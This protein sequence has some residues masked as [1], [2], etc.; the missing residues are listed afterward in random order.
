MVVKNSQI[1]IPVKLT[2]PLN[3]YNKVDVY[4][5]VSGLVIN[6]E[7]RLKP[8]NYYKKGEIILKIDDRIY[9]NNVLSQKSSL[10]NQMTKL[11]PDLSIDYPKS[12]EE[13]KNYLNKF[14]LDLPLQPLPEPSDNTEK[15]YIASRNLY[16]MYYSVRSME[17][18]LAKYTITAPF[19]GVISDGDINPGTLIRTGQKIAT[20]TSSDRFEMKAFASIKQVSRIKPGQKAVLYSEDIPGNFNAFVSRVNT[21]IDPSQTVRVYLESTDS[22]LKDGL[23]MTAVISTDPIENAAKISKALLNE[24]DSVFIIKNNILEARK[25]KVIAQVGDFVI[26]KGIENGEIL[27]DEKTDWARPGFIIQKNNGKNNSLI[28]QDKKPLDKKQ[29]VGR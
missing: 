11:I 26:V 4:S 25:V 20:L 10:L 7:K 18:T 28:N 6:S 3:A 9:K 15:Y 27:L 8:G 5:E 13:W 1:S 24:N 29:G 21:V 12:A 17:E 14:S 23:Y 19:S 2:G 16:T 22:K